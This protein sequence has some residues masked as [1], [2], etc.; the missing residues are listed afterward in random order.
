[1]HQRRPAAVNRPSAIPDRASER[2]LLACS[3]W[4]Y[5]GLIG[6]AVCGSGLILHFGA[7]AGGAATLALAIAGGVAAAAC[8]MRARVVLEG[9]R[10]TPTGIE[11]PLAGEADG[12]RREPSHRR[13]YAAAPPRPRMPTTVQIR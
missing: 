5:L 7:E 1:M 9:V 4:L 6:A 13:P 2:A 3:M 12:T 11:A 10:S 8:W